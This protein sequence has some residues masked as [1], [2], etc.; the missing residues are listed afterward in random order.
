MNTVMR[1]QTAFR[2]SEMYVENGF[3]QF[4]RDLMCSE[5]SDFYEEQL[6]ADSL[7]PHRRRKHLGEKQLKDEKV[8][9]SMKD[10][11]QRF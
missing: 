2:F 6:K 4:E 7:N 5:N 10:S 3:S 1:Q 8:R 11:K 9:F